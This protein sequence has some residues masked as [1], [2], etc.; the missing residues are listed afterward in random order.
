M[1]LQDSFMTPGFMWVSRIIRRNIWVSR[2]LG[3]QDSIQDSR[4]LGVQDSRTARIG[5]DW[6]VCFTI[7]RIGGADG[8][9][10]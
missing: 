5:Q 1:T 9:R 10:K 7:G 8:E 4:I 2:I 6:G 3:V